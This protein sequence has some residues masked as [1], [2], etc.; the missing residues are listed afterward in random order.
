M[1]EKRTGNSVRDTS[2]S[3]ADTGN[4]GDLA[5]LTAAVEKLA[6][7]L[8]GDHKKKDVWDVLSSISI[9]LST[10]VVALL[11]TYITSVYNDRAAARQSR[12]AQLETIYKFLEPISSDLPQKRHVAL[13]TLAAL[14]QETLSIKLT[15]FF[16]KDRGS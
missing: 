1:D 6:E 8:Q 2:V 16:A 10:V 12:D 14:G 13:I 3:A 5:R 9:F 4:S 7:S 11:G 15:E